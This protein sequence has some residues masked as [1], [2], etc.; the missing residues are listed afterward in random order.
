MKKLFGSGKYKRLMAIR[1]RAA[2]QSAKRRISRRFGGFKARDL[3]R[4]EV[5]APITFSMI[6]NPDGAIHFLSAVRGAPS[7]H[8]LFINLSGV[9]DTTCDASAVL[10]AMIESEHCK[11]KTYGNWPTDVRAK[12]MFYD[13]GFH[14]RVITQGQNPD[15]TGKGTIIRRDIYTDRNATEIA[16]ESARELVDFVRSKLSRNYDDKP[17]YGILIDVMENTF[18][19]ASLVMKGQVSW[20][21]TAYCDVERDKACYCFVDMGVGIF[22]SRSLSQRLR[23]AARSA[24]RGHADKLRALLQRQIP[25]GTGLPYRGKG[26]P[27]IYESGKEGRIESLVIASNEVFARPLLNEYQTL[28]RPFRG[29]FLYWET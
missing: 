20:W 21:A 19:H 6:R 22:K 8:R 16:N 11:S 1:Q 14:R 24:F 3:P 23:F 2:L 9:A 10:A 12:Q 27:W 13:S 25:S 15:E 7:G 5:V 29:T 4:Y 26:L 17:S 28:Q 18:T